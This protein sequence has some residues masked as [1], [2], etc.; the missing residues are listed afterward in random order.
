MGRRAG[1]YGCR[2]VFCCSRHVGGASSEVGARRV[3][4]NVVVVDVR[5]TPLICLLGGWAWRACGAG[6]AQ[7][8]QKRNSKTTHTS[9]W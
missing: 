1:W 4:G 7:G 5:S 3:G 2:R 8:G 9:L 6:L